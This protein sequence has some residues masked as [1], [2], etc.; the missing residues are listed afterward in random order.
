MGLRLGDIVLVHISLRRVGWIP[1]GVE[2]LLAA[3]KEVI[4]PS[5]TLVVPAFTSSNSHTSREFLAR[6]RGMTESET[7]SY[8]ALLPPFDPQ[9]T[10]SHEC[11][12]FTEIVRT[13]PDAVRSAHPQSSFAAIGPM[14]GQLMADHDRGDHLGERSPLAKLYAKRARV[15]LVGTGYETC[16]A[17]HLAEYRYIPSPPRTSY[18]CMIKTPAGPA[19]WKYEDVVL[20]DRDFAACGQEM[21]GFVA[22]TKGKI[23]RAGGRCFSVKAAVDFAQ[24]W[25]RRNR[26]S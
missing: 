16:T 12:L 1:D 19:W 17:F 20:D 24:T 14:A 21:E 13:Q 2:T 18:G 11:G 23:G 22:V 10:P 5:G 4:G 8:R 15:L 25:F 3:F 6:V 26:D 9:R 7:E